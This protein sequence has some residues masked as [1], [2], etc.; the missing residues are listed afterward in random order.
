MHSTVINASS[1]QSIGLLFCHESDTSVSTKVCQTVCIYGGIVSS[2]T[3]LSR[4]SMRVCLK[5]SNALVSPFL[6]IPYSVIT[7]GIWST[8]ITPVMF[9]IFL[10]GQPNY[11]L[12]STFL[13]SK[14]TL[15]F[16]PPPNIDF[17]A[18]WIVTSNYYI[19][20]AAMLQGT[21]LAIVSKQVGIWLP[22]ESTGFPFDLGKAA[23]GSGESH[24]AQLI[25]LPFLSLLPPC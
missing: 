1:Q 2:K 14:N 19:Q 22:S 6:S 24:L 4:Q 20:H 21:L 25:P 13:A 11:D 10:R 8:R 17:W 23:E 18:A 12:L 5:R 15:H 7:T 9:L 16:S 3:V